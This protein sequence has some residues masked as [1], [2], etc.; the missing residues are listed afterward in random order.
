MSRADPI[1][2]SRN[3]VNAPLTLLPSNMMGYSYSYYNSEEGRIADVLGHVLVSPDA[4]SL[5]TR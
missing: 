3:A 4:P 2:A 1:H 5:T